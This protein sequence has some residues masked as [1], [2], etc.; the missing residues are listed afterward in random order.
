MSEKLL[1]QILYGEGEIAEGQYG[2]DLSGFP[3]ILR[4]YQ[5]QMRGQSNMCKLDDACVS[6]GSLAVPIAAGEG[7]C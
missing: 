5:D 2:V 3:S 7:C 6:T 4:G 1:F